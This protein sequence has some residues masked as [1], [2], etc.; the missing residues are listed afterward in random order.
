MTTNEYLNTFRGGENQ[1]VQTQSSPK[2]I[3]QRDYNTMGQ[4]SETTNNPNGDE[5]QLAPSSDTRVRLRAMRD[6]EA[7]VYGPTDQDG[8]NILSILYETDGLL[9]PYTP[10]IAVSQEVN[11]KNIS[12]VH[13]I[14]DIDTYHHTPSVGLSVTGSFT[15]QN[16]REGRYA[17]AVLHFLRTASKMYFGKQDKDKGL[18]GLPPPV[19]IFTGYGNYMFDNLPVILKSHSYTLDKN[20]N[21][22]T[23]QTP[24]G[25]A[26]LPSMFEVTMQLQVQQT[27]RAMRTQFSLDKF[28]TG[29]LMTSGKDGGWI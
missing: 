10:T 29:E 16:Q 5:K 17:L 20:M 12:L 19:L 28:R 27:P 9:F 21:M 23:F 3:V 7:Q 6:Q 25:M 13:T 2:E 1:I 4:G 11:Y 22:V 26:K 14:G 15:V 18:A 8:S 24:N